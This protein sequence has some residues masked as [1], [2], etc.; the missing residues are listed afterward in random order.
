M[1]TI[2]EQEI[3]QQPQGLLDCYSYNIKLIK[4]IA[5]E[6]KTK[7]VRHIMMAARGSSD[8]ACNYFKY[9]CEIY[10]GIPVSFA[11][12]S[13]LTLYNGK[14]D[15]S[16]TMVIGVSQS[17]KAADVM[18]ILNRA[19]NQGSITV[20]VTNNLSSPMATCSK[21]HIF[22]NVG[23]EKSVAATKTYMA[24]M[25]ALA[26]IAAEMSENEQLK[27]DLQQAPAKISE[28]IKL[29][30]QIGES[31]QRYVK[32]TDCYVLSRGINYAAAQE[33]GLKIQ[34]TTYIKARAYAIS[35]FHHGPFAVVDNKTY[36][37]ILAPSDK[38]QKDAEEMIDKVAATGADLT[39]FTDN[40]KLAD[41]VNSLV[42]LPACPESI[43]PFIYVTCA[44]MFACYLSVARGLNP[45]APRGL[46][47]VTIT[48]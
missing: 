8:N 16:D 40:A 38:S 5:L 44:Q 25:Y 26:L 24:Q 32:A 21:F 41:K 37:L 9:M 48:K 45:D 35:D 47:K 11:A 2:M 46:K 34:E 1:S 4:E 36:V 18:E 31:A 20:S 28:V 22:L 39:V 19:K 14:L 7:N 17:G 23:E 6:A 43:S 30:K 27:K 33:T 10:V 42:L 13:V 12:P 29:S 15:L 3:A